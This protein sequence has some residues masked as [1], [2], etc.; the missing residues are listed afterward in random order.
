MGNYSSALPLFEEVRQI[1][2]KTLGKEHSYYAISCNNLAECYRLYGQYQKALPLYIESKNIQE[3][4]NGKQHPSYAN[5]CSNLSFLYKLMGNYSEALPL[6]IEASKIYEKTLGRQ[7]PNYAI[8]ANNLGAIYQETGDLKKAEIQFLTA[9]QNINYQISQNF[10]F[11]TEKEK[12]LFI[13]NIELNFQTIHSFA[14]DYKE[15]KPGFVEINYNNE[16]AYKGAVLKS[17]KAAVDA[18]LNSNIPELIAIYDNLSISKKKLGHQQSLSIATRTMNTDSLEQV[19][20]NMESKL[21]YE[22][23]KYPELSKFS[24]FNKTP[25][26]KDVQKALKPG[27]AAIEFISFR[28]R[29]RKKWTDSIFYCALVLRKELKY[30][31]MI[32]LF[33]EPQLQE[34]LPTSSGNSSGIDNL[35]Q[36]NGTITSK[37][38]GYHLYNLIW[39]PIESELQNIKTIYFAPSGLLHKISFNAIALPDK[40]FLSDKYKLNAL[41]STAIIVKN[42]QEFKIGQSSDIQIYG[43]IS[44][45]V[46]NDEMLSF[47]GKYHKPDNQEIT[48]FRPA[49]HGVAKRGESWSYLPGTLDEA[50]NISNLFNSAKLK[51]NFLS[52]KEANEESFKTLNGRNSP[53]I[54]HIATHGFFMPD[55]KKEYSDLDIRGISSFKASDNPL[56]RSGLMFSGSNAAWNND[57]IPSEVEDGILTANEISQM[58]LPNTNLV[59]LSA[60]ETGLGEIKGGEGVFGLQR[61]LKMAGVD[62]IIMSLWQVPD[63]QTSELMQLFYKNLISGQTVRDSFSE[64]QNDLKVKYKE[65]PFSWAA[66]VL[67]E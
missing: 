7:H 11:L 1:Y 2:E 37:N 39:Q 22:I 27:E 26:W 28:Y 47:A 9:N 52:G 6:S 8:N 19:A 36:L 67:I 33:K 62:Y 60:C 3:K 44:Y 45:R 23:Q 4:T 13:Q 61:S 51:V 30:P 32:F 53:A 14:Y 55:P 56:F 50:Q 20:N 21:L 34:L 40:R 59:V 42:K 43:G 46:S 10:Y 63:E 38:D 15:Q 35:Y 58:Y 25:D 66:F 12:E 49:I 24:N 16:L 57:S 54:I 65:S 64:A 48:A 18:V 29:D 5:A 17:S 31:K 41:S